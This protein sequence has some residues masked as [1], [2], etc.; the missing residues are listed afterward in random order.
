MGPSGCGKSTLLHLMGGLD[1]P[2]SGEVWVNDQPVHRMHETAL[3]LFRREYV[4]VVFQFFNLLPQLTALEN[5]VFPLRLLGISASESESRAAN[6]LEAVGLQGKSQRL[7]SEIS[8]GEQQRVAIARALVHRPHI[9]LADEPTG[10][11]DSATSA[12]VLKILKDLH[13]TYHTTLLLVTHA[14]EVSRAATRVVTMHDG[15]FVANGVVPS[16]KS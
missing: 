10:N 11:L 7:P 3:S 8:G 14:A 6:L 16:S 2:T 15:Q 13:D 9:V 1:T 5:V 4:G 12:Y